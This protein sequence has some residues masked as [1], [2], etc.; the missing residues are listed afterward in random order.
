MSY[1]IRAYM[2]GNGTTDWRVEL[3][4]S[5]AYICDVRLSISSMLNGSHYYTATSCRTAPS[6]SASGIGPPFATS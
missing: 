4:D 1:K 6:I 2:T 5:G 3:A